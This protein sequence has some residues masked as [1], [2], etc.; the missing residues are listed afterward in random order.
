[1]FKRTR[2][3]YQQGSL[4]LEERKKGPA[5]WVCRWWEND[6]H[7]R[8]VRRKQQIGT[9]EQYPNESAA[10]SASDA[11]RL[12]IN[13]Q[14]RRKGLP[15][16]VS[17]LW[18]HY[19]CKELPLKEISTQD[20]Y[21]VFA[22]NWILPRWGSMSLDRVKTVEVEQWLRAT[23]VANGTKAKIKTVM[24]AMFSH[25]VRWEFST[26]NP[27]SS[28]IPVGS[29]AKRGP[30]VGVRVSAKRQKDPLVLSPE[31]VKLGL[32]EMQFRDQLLVFLMGALGTRRGET[33]ALR[34]MDCDFQ[35]G[36]FYIR[37]SYYWRRGGHLKDT[38]TEG[39]AKPLPM[40]PALKNALLE[41]GCKAG[42][43]YRPTSCSRPFARR[44]GSRSTL[45]QY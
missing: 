15:R 39:S 43:R 22:K 19:T 32:A 45:R 17:A 18:E 42:T 2:T 41:W 1:L 3:S 6:L 38:K 44:D 36:V 23:D 21:T 16:T 11:L 40:H 25:A 30:S 28:G 8:P 26:H 7:G 4:T 37:H 20:T 5:V 14:S 29:G 9:L 27:I 13:D 24:S 33:A 31:E 10:Q 35:N 34:W 12:T